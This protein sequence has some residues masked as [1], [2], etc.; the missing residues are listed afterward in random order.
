MRLRRRI[1]LSFGMFSLVNACVPLFILEA[2]RL[3]RQDIITE[4]NLAAGDAKTEGA[5]S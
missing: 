2:A 1:L 5:H 4:R 3:S